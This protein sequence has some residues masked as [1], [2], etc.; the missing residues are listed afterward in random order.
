MGISTFL[1]SW[2]SSVVLRTCVCGSGVSSGGCTS[3]APEGQPGTTTARAAADFFDFGG[4]VFFAVCAG[5]ANTTMKERHTIPR[6][7][8]LMTTLLSLF[9]GG[10]PRWNSIVTLG[11]AACAG[12]EL[13]EREAE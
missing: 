8:R 7:D 1:R 10:R 5:A 9:C 2:T 3:S 4:V 13:R 6:T 11:S 12:Q